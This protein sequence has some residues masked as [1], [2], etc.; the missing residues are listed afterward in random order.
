MQRYNL[1]LKG[2]VYT[3]GD[4]YNLIPILRQQV[5][6]G[7]TVNIQ[8]EVNLKTA[9]FSTNLTTPSLMSV[10]YFYVPHRLVWDGW[11]DF[12]S[13][14]EGAP[15]FPE[16][17]TA[18]AYFFDKFPAGNTNGH[19][20]LYR[21]AYKLIY[22]EYFGTE[23]M[24]GFEW[25]DDITDDTVVTP[26]NTRNPEQFVSKLKV[27]TAA[28]A[29]PEFTVVSNQIPL[30]EFYR[31]M[32]NARSKQRSQM[33]GN[34]YV[35]TLARMG[36]D[37]SWMIS[38]RPE[39]LGTKSKLVG[40]QLT[41]NTADTNT[42]YEIAR[43]S[44]NLSVNISNKHF[45]EHGYIVGVASVRPIVVT[46]DRSANDCIPSMYT[47]GNAPTNEDWLDSFYSADN[48]QTRDSI[49]S[50]VVDVTTTQQAY[51]ER[52]AYLKHGEWL[53][54]NGSSW[55]C[56]NNNPVTFNDLIYPNSNLFDFTQELGGSQV[57]ITTSHKVGGK[58]PVGKSVA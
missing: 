1:N 12:I 58:I 35:D 52:F 19:S 15:S 24:G 34:K 27:D 32:M 48:T 13:K 50:Y 26:F 8:D 55:A 30:N 36:V 28:I 3:Q 37:A 31:N 5:V 7:Q 56:V 23:S 22:N 47:A 2:G 18:G 14:E 51:A 4:T 9:A 20:S 45:A 17:N 11:T 40:P 41:A 53:S 38:E 33:T 29:D 16:T 57:A 43:Y 54:G 6:P 39:F 42:G 25:Y 46:V 21:R 49:T 44:C 10:W